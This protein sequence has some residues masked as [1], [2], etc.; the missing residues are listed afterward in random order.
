MLTFTAVLSAGVWLAAL[1]L[2]MLSDRNVH[3]RKLAVVA[4]LGSAAP[5]AVITLS[6][7]GQ[8]WAGLLAGATTGAAAAL[9]FLHGRARPRE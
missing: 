9:L 1:V 6:L 4:S 2:A 7:T 5:I 3:D 8:S